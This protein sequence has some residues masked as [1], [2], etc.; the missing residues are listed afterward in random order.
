[1]YDNVFVFLKVSSFFIEP[2]F[3]KNV[4]SKEILF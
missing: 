2:L 3:D 4:N 1:M